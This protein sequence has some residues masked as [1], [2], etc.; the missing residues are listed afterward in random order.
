MDNNRIIYLDWLRVVAAFMVVGIH[1]YGML[2]LDCPKGMA[3]YYLGFWTGEIVR[4]AVSVF[5]L[6]SGALLLRPEYDAAP[7]KMMH[8]AL[9]TLVL[10]LIW[11]F[12]YAIVS[13]HSITIKG[14]I[15][16]TI[17]GPFHFWFFE[18]L[19]GLYLLTP[20]FKAI[21]AYKDGLIARYYLALFIIFGIIVSSLQAIPYCHKWIMDITS[22]VPVE[23]LGFAGYFFMGHYLSQ[24]KIRKSPW[25]WIAI[26]ISAVLVQG[27]IT[28]HVDMQYASDK[29]WIITFIEASSLFMVFA[30]L[31]EIRLFQW[32]GITAISSLAMGVY[33]LHPLLSES[34]PYQYYT[35]P[36]YGLEV[37]GIFGGS[38]LISYLIMKVPVAGKWLL[39]L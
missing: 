39:S 22:K 23:W 18:I 24:L 34:I 37:L 6:I 4:S 35:A 14:L 5:F 15:F 7:R 16:S 27:W 31:K 2:Y 29:F 33:I 21:V 32:Q 17:K 36:L 10:M 12:V 38:M 8:K 20:V 3:E 28:A 1:T 13:V 11:S 25:M 19:I 26:F 9:K 30:S